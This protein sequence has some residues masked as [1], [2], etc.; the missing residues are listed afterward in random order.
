MF[1]G[2]LIISSIVAKHANY[3]IQLYTKL[4]AHQKIKNMLDK[5]VVVNLGGLHAVLVAPLALLSCSEWYMNQHFPHVEAG[6]LRMMVQ[7]VATGI[8]KKGSEV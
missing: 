3:T 8:E 6:K 2:A 7:D 5:L 4:P 1:T